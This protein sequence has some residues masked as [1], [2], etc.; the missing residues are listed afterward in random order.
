MAD[1]FNRS[2]TGR[3]A[4]VVGALLHAIPKPKRVLDVG[5][6]TGEVGRYLKDTTGARV[7]G[8]EMMPDMA[9]V[10]SAQLDR[11]YG[12]TVEQFLASDEATGPY[13]A[14][15]LADV[16]EHTQDPWAILRQFAGMLSPEG[17]IVI[18]LPNIRHW[19]TLYHLGVRGEWPYNDRGIF[20]RTHLRWFTHKNMVD[21]IQGAGLKIVD[22]R[23]NYRI[24][25][26]FT[27]WNRF[28]KYAK[29][30]LVG[31]FFAFQYIFACAVDRAAARKAA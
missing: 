12:K 30:P 31:R 11:V 19:S 2:Y 5:C 29:L 28:S 24:T 21:L 10:A 4:D 25:E 26:G 15:I 14:V 9:E 16:L 6:A 23:T 18:S 20:D 13:D 17:R 1:A 22:T 3:R 8:V 7:E 27:R